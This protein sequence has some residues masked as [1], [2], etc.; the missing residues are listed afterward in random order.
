MPAH[1]RDEVRV[2]VDV[3]D[4]H[5]TIVECRAPWRADAGAEWTRFRIARLRYMKGTGMWSLYWR[6]R[7]LRFHGYDLLP[8]TDGVE[9]L[10]AELDRDPT[11][12]FWG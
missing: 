7:N 6:D 8:P 9:E 1:V 11:A 12:I 10:L 2:E 5:L 3:S 4:R